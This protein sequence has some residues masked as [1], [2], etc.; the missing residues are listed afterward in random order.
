MP[1]STK[2]TLGTGVLAAVLSFGM[3]AYAQP[4]APPLGSP[5]SPGTTNLLPPPPGAPGGSAGA[6]SQSSTPSTTS[7]GSSPSTTSTTAPP[8]VTP[9]GPIDRSVTPSREG[10]NCAAAQARYSEVVY[11]INALRAKNE[12]TDEESGLNQ[13]RQ[14][15]EQYITYR[16][17]DCA[18]PRLAL[19][20]KSAEPR[21]IP[22][23]SPPPQPAE[24][25]LIPRGP[26]PPSPQELHQ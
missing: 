10:L 5:P 17:Q 3:A 9:P 18:L 15:L 22:S 8:E 20:P 13:E 7:V 25:R 14:N 26:P 21:V 6:P 11:K 12:Y 4:S 19:V 16:L 23:G 2:I 24:P 1:T